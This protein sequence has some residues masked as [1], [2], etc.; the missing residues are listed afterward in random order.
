MSGDAAAPPESTPTSRARSHASWIVAAASILALVAGVL[1]LHHEVLFEG[2]VYHMDDAADNYYPSRTAAWRTIL[3]GH[4]PVW[5]RGSWT[6]WPLNA[7]PYYGVFYPLSVI[8]SLAGMV[9]GLG[10]SIAVH[11]LLA[12]LAMLWLL[13]RR[14]LDRGAALLGA[15]S[16]GFSSFMVCR[17]RHIIFPQMMAWLPLVL[18]GLEGWLTNRRQRELVLLALALGMC[19]LCG[20]LPLFPFLLLFLAAYALPR[21]LAATSGGW[22]PRLGQLGLLALVAGCGLLL[23]AVALLPTVAHLPESPRSLGASYRFA[24]SY[25]WPDLRYL[26]TLVVA[27]LFGTEERARWYGAFNHWEMAGYYAG[28]LV[29]L[30]APFGLARARRRPE[31]AGLALVSLLGI[32]LAFGEKSPLQR[33]FFA[34]VPLYGA[35]RCPTR[36]LVMFLAAAPILAAEGWTWLIERRIERRLRLGLVLAGLLLAGGLAGFIVLRHDPR[37]AF[38]GVVMTRHAFAHLVAVVALGGALLTLVLTASVPRRVGGLALALLTLCELVVLDRGYLQ[39]RPGDWAAGTERF[40]A[41]DWL[42]EQKPADRFI[43]AADG[44]FRLLNLGMTYGIE[45]ASGYGSILIWRYTNLFWTI[46]HGRPYSKHPLEDDLSATALR[47]FPASLVDLLNIR[48]FIGTAPPTPRWIERYR[49][50]PGAPPRA[51]HEPW[52]DPQLRVYENPSVMPRAFVVYGARVEPDEKRQI[53]AMLTFDP[54]RIALLDRA[55]SPPPVGDGRSS[56]TARIVESSSVSLKI[57]A[58]AEAP[59]ILVVSEAYYPGWSATLDGQPIEL[60]RADYAFRG[61]ALPAGRHV[62]EMRFRSRP[63]EL[64]LVLSGLG[65]LGILGLGLLGR[66]RR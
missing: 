33:F 21:V 38:P 41:V 55:P 32:A 26:G 43:P 29:V 14:G 42:L 57:E 6:G 56:N 40:S 11:M 1:Y 12:S 13:R 61:V 23:G 62:V 4:L 28:A 25:G 35:L 9:R 16:F 10:V 24:S 46:N 53:E 65:L 17:I 2:A 44:P 39:P 34:H 63:T 30:L 60:L 47:R 20:A 37:P 18:V 5:E 59:G 52:W 49:P 58:E 31:L 64:G 15:V 66:R 8:F 3:S 50:L 22:R 19:L 7:D 27:N 54:R 45:G 48:W 36:A 51:R